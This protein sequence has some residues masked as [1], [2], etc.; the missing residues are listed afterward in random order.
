MPDVILP[1]LNE[2]AALPTVLASIP[3]GWTAI[4]VDNGSTDGSAELAREGGARLVHEPQRGF[5]AACYAGLMAA[6]TE[7][8]ACTPP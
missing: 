5:G 4:V 6:T 3:A 8:V 1:V 7:I 2:A